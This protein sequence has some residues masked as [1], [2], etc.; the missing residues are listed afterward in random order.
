MIPEE[1]AQLLYAQYKA[2]TGS[3]NPFWM[4]LLME[5]YEIL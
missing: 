1:I 2:E 4:W 3:P 5:E